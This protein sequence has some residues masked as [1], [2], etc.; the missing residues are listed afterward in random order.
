VAEYFLGPQPGQNF[1]I[2]VQLHPMTAG[3]AKGHLAAQ[4]VQSIAHGITVVALVAGRLAQ[5]VDHLG[6]GNIAGIA[7]AQVDDVHAGSAFPVF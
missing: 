3:I 7:H 1:G 4:V 5:L 2:R 6:V